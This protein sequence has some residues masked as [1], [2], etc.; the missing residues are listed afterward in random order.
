MDA[1]P[2]W[3][4]PVEAVLAELE[5]APTG[6]SADEARA[7]LKRYGPNE[8]APPRRFEP[9]REIASYLVNPLVLTLLCASA[10]SAIFGQVVSS[11]VVAVPAWRRESSCLH[12][13]CAVARL[14]PSA[15][16][17]L[18]HPRPDDRDVPGPRRGREALVL[19][20]LAHVMFPCARG[21]RLG[22]PRPSCRSAA[23]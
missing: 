16:A 12:A 18:R 21:R 7:R 19:S 6:L 11:L 5:S 10:V 22:S 14:H 9:L 1:Q 20:G 23:P 13:A 17:L 4:R 2:F 15:P 8:P 3:A